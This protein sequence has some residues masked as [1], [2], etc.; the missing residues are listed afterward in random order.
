MDDKKYW[1]IHLNLRIIVTGLSVPLFCPD[2]DN[3]QSTVSIDQVRSPF[4]LMMEL[5]YVASSSHGIRQ[6][7]L[8][9]H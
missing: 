7:R 5:W 9:D 2:Q 6:P 1:S 3:N 4:A 8:T